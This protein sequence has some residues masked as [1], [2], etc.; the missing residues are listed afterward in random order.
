MWTLP[1]HAQRVPS[2]RSAQSIACEQIQ[3]LLQ[4]PP[5]QQALNLFIGDAKYSSGK[6]F[7]RVPLSCANAVCLVRLRSNSVLYLRAPQPVTPKWGHPRWYGQRFALNRSQQ[8]PPCDEEV[9]EPLPEGGKW[10]VQAWGRTLRRGYLP[11]EGTLLCCERLDEEGKPKYARPLW[12]W[13][14]GERRGEITPLQ[15]FG[16]YRRRFDVEHTFRFLKRRMLLTAYQTPDVEQEEH[17]VSVVLLACA[18]LFLVRDVAL[19]EVYAWQRHK[20]KRQE[21]GVRSPSAVQRVFGEIVK[22]LGEVA[23][24]VKP[25]G[26][27]P[28]RAIG[29]RLPARARR[30]V[31]RKGC[32][33]P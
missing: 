31:V 29:Y 13:M 14:V 25:R 6:Q 17:W 26:K 33:S 22:G 28:G 3:H 7:V 24:V 19:Q 20:A 9:E 18:Q 5:F 10:R 11:L 32:R 1:L 27:S 8:L 30:E 2:N 15:V 12:L 23:Y 4:H 16:W 21:G